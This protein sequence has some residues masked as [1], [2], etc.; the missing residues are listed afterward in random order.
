MADS[1]AE[2]TINATSNNFKATADYFPAQGQGEPLTVEQVK[3]KLAERGI[4]TGINED[5]IRYLCDCIRPLKAFVLAEAIAP[6][7]GENARIEQYVAISKRAKAAERDDGGVDFKQLGE[8][9]SVSKGQTLFKRFPP[10]RGKPG[11]D[12]RGNEIPGI[13]GKNIRIALGNGTAYDKQNPDL[14]VAAIEGEL[15]LRNGVLHVSEIHEVK[16]DVDYSTGN[17]K[18]LGSIRIRGTVRSGFSVEAGGSVQINGNIEDATVI[19]GSD[20]TVLGGFAGTGQGV[21]NAGR[22]VFIK[23][24]ENQ[25]IEAGRDII[26]NG[27]SYHSNLRAGRSVLAKSGKGTIVGGC[28][29]AKHS[30][31]AVRFGSVACVPTII[32]VGIDPSLAERLKFLDEEIDQA[33]KSIMKLE[34]SVIFLYKLKI[35]GKG[36]LPPDKAE[37]LAKL[38]TARKGIPEK[39]VQ[40]QGKREIMVQEQSDVELAFAVADA[41]VFPKVKVFIGNQWI[42]NEDTL[43][44]SIFKMCEGDVIR[45]SK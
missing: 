34:Q 11:Y 41:G 27:I 28:S 39:L 23:F 22:D 19:A 24:V 6:E 36:Q 1:D 38:E 16:E 10:T 40:L 29:E 26:L 15:I 9:T 18:F 37:L 8:I 7:T 4:T 5:G 42:T 30:V 32:K 17:L 25:R 3:A 14:V 12:I 35:E 33:Q 2:I 43:G 20:V 21:V 13:L 31:E 44:P 45:L